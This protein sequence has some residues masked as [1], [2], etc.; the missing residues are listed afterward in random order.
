MSRRRIARSDPRS[1]TVE[2]ARRRFDLSVGP[3]IRA[4]L[5]R[6]DDEEHILLVTVHHIDRGRLVDR[7]DHA[8]TGRALRCLLSR[9]GLSA[10][11][12]AAP[13]RRFRRL[14]KEWLESS[15]LDD[16]LAYWTRQLADL[17]LLEIPTDRPRPPVQTSNGHIESI[18]LSKHL[19]DDLKALSNGQGSPSSCCSLAVAQG[20][21]RRT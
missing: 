14:A 21:A 15:D 10:G 1:L 2:E 3:L 16:Q 19:T 17:P 4:S 5:L 12:P 9:T 6:L 11:R 20:A 18:V 8:G 7:R 13:V